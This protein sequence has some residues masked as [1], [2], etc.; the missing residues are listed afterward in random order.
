MIMPNI[1]NYCQPIYICEQNEEEE[2]EKKG[3]GEKKIKNSLLF[4]I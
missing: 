1:C 2:E 3:E 4:Y